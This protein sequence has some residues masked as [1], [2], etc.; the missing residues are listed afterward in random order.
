MYIFILEEA[1]TLP[2]HLMV[3]YKIMFKSRKWATFYMKKERVDL[4]KTALE[5]DHEW[6]SMFKSCSQIGW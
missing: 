4:L 6:S 3:D 5:V 2:Y 1:G